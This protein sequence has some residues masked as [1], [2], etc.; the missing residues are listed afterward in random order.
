MRLVTGLSASPTEGECIKQEVDS[1]VSATA[2]LS[3]DRYCW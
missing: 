1:R 2:G 3:A